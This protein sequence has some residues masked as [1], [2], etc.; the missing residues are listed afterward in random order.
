M[1]SS[2]TRPTALVEAPSPVKTRR[3]EMSGT[4]SITWVGTTSPEGRSSKATR[5]ATKWSTLTLYRLNSRNTARVRSSTQPPSCS[6][7]R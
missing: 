7:A 5:T 4:E 3:S 2:T 1:N 6:E